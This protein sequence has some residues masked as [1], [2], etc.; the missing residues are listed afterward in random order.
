MKKVLLLILVLGL[1]LTFCSK[2]STSSEEE[3]EDTIT[4]E[5]TVI[6]NG[7]PAQNVF[8]DVEATIWEWVI[9]RDS[10]MHTDAMEAS[11]TDP[12]ITDQYG[13][14]KIIYSKQSIPSRNGII[15]DKITIR[16]GFTIVLEDTEERVI[17]KNGS[18]SLTFEI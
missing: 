6:K 12:E 14:V 7:S 10:G 9:N 17:E 2:D 3:T 18:L 4:L 11:R 8:V 5:I 13:K 16:E 1:T 15:I